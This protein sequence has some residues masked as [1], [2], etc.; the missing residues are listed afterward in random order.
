MRVRASARMRCAGAE[1]GV[2]LLTS[3]PSR[4]TQKQKNMVKAKKVQ[5]AS[6]GLGEVSR[7]V[8]STRVKGRVGVV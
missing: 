2:A 5:E 7:V 3:L 6:E 8:G 1:Q 4:R